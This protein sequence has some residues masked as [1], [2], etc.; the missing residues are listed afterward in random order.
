ML[1]FLSA[2]VLVRVV[3]ASPAALTNVL[4]TAIVPQ[5]WKLIGPAEGS[6]YVQ[7]SVALAQPGLGELKK[8][9]ADT[10]NIKNSEFG[11][12]LTKLQV[13]Q[14][15]SPRDD[16]VSSVV[17]WLTGS[18]VEEIRAESAWVHFAG[19]V[20]TMNEILKCEFNQ[21]VSPSGN[22]VL[23]ALEYSI[24]NHLAG[25]IQ[26]IYPTT[27]FVEASKVKPVQELATQDLIR[28]Q[29]QSTPSCHDYVT[30]DCLVDL[31]NIT[32]I[33]PDALSGSTLGI[34][35]FL[36]EYPTQAGMHQFLQDH[37]PRRN[38]SGY[39]ADYN[40]TI[41]S[42]N[43]GNT[44]DTGS[45]GEAM[46]DTFYTLPFTQPLPVAYLSTGGR[47]PY[48]GPDGSNMTDS[49][50]NVNE[51]WIEFLEYLLAL[52]DDTLPKVLS[53][54]YTDDEQSTPKPF[55]FKICDM[56]MQLGAR[57]VSVL[58]ASGDGGAD[59]NGQNL[60]C[61][62][63]DGPLK[64]QNR[65]LST[66]PASCPY[67]TSIGATALYVP[68]EPTSWS[69]GGFSEYF[70]TPEWQKNFTQQ[71]I[72][73]IGDQHAGWYN[74]SGRGV[75]DLTLVGVR[76]LI[77][78]SG[79]S[80]YTAKGTSASTPVWASMITLINDHRLRAGKPTLGWLNP[81][82]Y[83]DEVRSTLVD[84]TSGRTGGCT[85][86]DGQVETGWD[87]LNG[88]DPATGLGAPNFKK[89]LELLG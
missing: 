79:R 82:L 58:V 88:W 6:L 70:E 25:D 21:Y 10:S 18:N 8:R 81:L 68:F 63:N 80:A 44:T 56:F 4:E 89:L 7:L 45:G 30:P 76:Y 83:T 16:T 46:L 86:G 2:L 5:D 48:I 61:A 85:Y 23:R 75:P 24:P 17:G 22:L 84:L 33:P 43:G 37:S 38:A 28:R 67:V 34:A 11:K 39:S 51:P 13:E 35:G 27:Q 78:G 54:S 87:A 26:F 74:A 64:G 49:P 77:G 71:Y 29:A 19:P 32:Y 12:H 69:S 9:L 65:F 60:Q 59:G 52:D 40:F 31:Y 50:S 15:S 20:E 73:N 57:G 14:Y 1:R 36:E 55:A 47:G 41:T 53:I 72:N 42:V 66:F 3:L 62:A